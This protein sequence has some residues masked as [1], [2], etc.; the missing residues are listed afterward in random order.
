MVAIMEL[1]QN[2]QST[3]KLINIHNRHETKRI[4]P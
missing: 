4:L 1:I 3:V 2:L